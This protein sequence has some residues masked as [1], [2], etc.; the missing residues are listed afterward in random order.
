MVAKQYRCSLRI[1]FTF[2]SL[3]VIFIDSS[4]AD[5]SSKYFKSNDSTV[6]KNIDKKSSNINDENPIITIDSFDT[7]KLNDLDDYQVKKS[8]LDKIIRKDQ[9]TNSNRYT[10]DRLENLAEK[11]SF[12]YKDKG[13]ILTKVFFPPQSLNNGTL[14][15]DIVMGEIEAVSSNRNEYYSEKRLTRP[16]KDI[17]NKPAYIPTLESSLIELNQYP[18]INLGASFREGSSIGKTHINIQVQDEKFSDFNFSLDNYGSKYT[19][20]MRGMLK[21]NFYNLA[22]QAD[23]LNINILGTVNPTNS[24]Y[25]GSSY[26]FKIEPYTNNAILNSIFRYG[27]NATLGY[28]QTRY[29]AGGDI[30][31]I[32]Y[33][34]KA[35]SAY[36]RLDK[37]FILRNRL[38]FNSGIMLS[39]KIAETTQNNIENNDDRLS[40]FTWSNRL[41]WNDNFISPSAT[42]INIDIHQGL[43]GFAGALENGSDDINRKGEKDGITITAPMDYLRYNLIVNRNQ[44]AGPYQ[45]ISKLNIQYTNDLMHASEL[46]NL[47]GSGA[48]RGYANSDFSGD[49]TSIISFELVGKSNA[50]KLALPISDLKLAG[51][52]DYGLGERLH[53]LPREDE[54]AEMASIGGYAQ[55]INE[56]KFS[57]KMELAI[58]LKAVGDS[59]KNGLEVLFNFERGF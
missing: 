27:F 12:Y 40:I 1:V 30:Q 13:L 24:V 14:Y 21:A 18:G 32:N 46:S 17:I 25:F 55:F 49:R 19:G 57:S 48:V 58:P 31:A 43:P 33:E 3:S 41:T 28:Q 50:R 37:D 4:N 20:A 47:G 2:F 56:G 5:I 10:V 8:D 26:R 11:L 15:M 7:S 42:V 44:S 45:F 35:S 36:T 23:Q 52:I 59:K 16:F 9:K 51:F 29:E 39:R 38:K 22:D 53:P 6:F 54:Q 34:G